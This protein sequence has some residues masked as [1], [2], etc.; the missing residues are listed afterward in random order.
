MGTAGWLE[1][2]AGG[3]YRTDG[4]LVVEVWWE[5]GRMMAAAR[6]TT[7]WF[8]GGWRGTGGRKH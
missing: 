5:R 1:G 7:S 6:K 8:G 3:G 4:S 2:R